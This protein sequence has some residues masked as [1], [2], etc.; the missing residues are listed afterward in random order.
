M[1]NVKVELAQALGAACVRQAGELTPYMWAT[2]MSSPA[3]GE[4]E[5]KDEN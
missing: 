1:T 4:P 3:A 5:N 2:V